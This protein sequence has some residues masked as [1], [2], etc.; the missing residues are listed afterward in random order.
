[1]GICPS[2]PPSSRCRDCKE[3]FETTP[4]TTLLPNEQLAIKRP[5]R[6]RIF[7]VVVFYWF[8]T[9]PSRKNF[10]FIITSVRLRQIKFIIVLSHTFLVLKHVWPQTISVIIKKWLALK[11]M[12][13]YPSHV[14][15]KT[16]SKTRN[17]IDEGGRKLH[18]YGG[19][20]LW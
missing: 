4:L 3:I 8:W 10:I 1:M 5:Q 17:K 7:T 15:N 20:Q 14:L 9:Q 11:N 2:R 19:G 12:S 18:I 13:N 6:R 16:A